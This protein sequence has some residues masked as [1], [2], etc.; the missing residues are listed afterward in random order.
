MYI[1][2]APAHSND[3]LRRQL[4]NV[5]RILANQ[6]DKR[7]DDAL[8]LRQEISSKWAYQVTEGKWF[9]W[10]TTFAPP[11]IRRLKGVNWR[12]YGML[13]F[14]GYHVGE[15]QPTPPNVRRCI[16]EYAFECHLPPLNDLKYYQEW[17]APQTAPRLKKLADTLAAFARNAKRRDIRSLAAAIDDWESDL[18]FLRDK[19][20]VGFFHF[21]WPAT[22]VN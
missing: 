18:E 9:P 2:L 5:F 3:C 15:T 14:L 13:R 4:R 6:E 7:R 16:L 22:D 20:Y 11:G 8:K 21:G 12:P 10:P 1:A 19:Y 17:G